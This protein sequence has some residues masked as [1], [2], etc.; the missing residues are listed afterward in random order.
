MLLLGHNAPAQYRTLLEEDRIVEW[1]TVWLFFAAG[2]L[3]AR[4]AVRERRLFDGLV[5]SFCVF[6]AGE[7]FSWGQRLLGYRP[8]E[9]FLQNNFQ[10]EVNVHNLSQSFFQPKWVL[11]AALAG[12]GIVLPLW[13][14][15]IGLR[16]LLARLGATPPSIDVLPWFTA[17]IALLIWYPLILTGEWVEAFSGGL[18][19]VSVR[20]SLRTVWTTLASAAIFGAAMSTATDAVERQ[21]DRARIACA[22][23]EAQSLVEDVVSRAGTHRLWR[24]HRVHKRL[25]SSFDE[26]LD[27]GGIRPFGTLLCAQIGGDDSELRH[28]YGIDPW[29]SPYWL[30]VETIA[31][32]ERQVAVYS[33]GPNRRR[34]GDAGD[35]ISVTSLKAVAF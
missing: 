27:A 13:S 18:F 33:F 9:F 12:Y 6:V 1:A 28:T 2:L 35:D 30:L 3:G 20:P 24:M 4:N 10:Q 26:Y 19:L 11:I 7:E 34:D 29:G 32:G 16:P 17:A 5:A 22:A 31:A 14:R 25:W 21:R 15:A 8:P 23:A